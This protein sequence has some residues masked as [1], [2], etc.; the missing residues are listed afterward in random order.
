MSR[1]DVNWS[2]WRSF[3]AVLQTGSLSAAARSLSL[4]QPT[5]G[6]HIDNLEDA[7]GAPLFLRSQDGLTPTPFAL[8]LEPKAQA[9]AMSAQ[10]MKR[11]AKTGST[12]L[13][14]TVRIT[15]SEIV[16]V[17]VLPPI[18]R[19]FRVKY[20]RVALELVLSN[21]QD[22]LLKA[23]ADI[24]VRMIRPKQKRLIAKK[25]GDVPIGL[26]AHD[27][28]LEKRSIPPSI[29]D[30]FDHDLIGIDRDVKRWAGMILNGRPITPDD[31]SFRCD[32]DIGQLAA[33]RAGLGIGVCQRIIA[34]SDPNLIEVLPTQIQ[35]ALEMWIVM[36]EDLKSHQSA[37][38]V[39]EHLAKELP[40]AI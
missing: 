23:D 16:G 29:V 4:T 30:L 36:H 14:G 22:D 40:N 9:M 19:G 15:A 33:L 39:F 32:S 26:Y 28:Y 20:P 11:L 13:E 25:V 21:T 34:K 8:S 3:L 27:S 31:L 10:A 2:Y 7:L 17:E 35:I 6:R 18:L 12:A 24:A 37:R 38:A 1:K 5:V